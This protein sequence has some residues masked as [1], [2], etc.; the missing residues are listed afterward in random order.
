MT[1]YHPE[2]RPTFSEIRQYIEERLEVCEPAVE[3]EWFSPLLP[4][5]EDVP[6][7]CPSMGESNEWEV[8]DTD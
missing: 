3:Q 2:D 7:V 6:T 1:Q 4:D 8:W 5:T